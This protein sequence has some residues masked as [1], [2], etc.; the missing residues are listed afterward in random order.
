MGVCALQQDRHFRMR[1][2]R[3]PREQD[4]GGPGDVPAESTPTGRPESHR[5]CLGKAGMEHAAQ[6]QARAKPHGAN[7]IRMAADVH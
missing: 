6:R 2:K 7:T 5:W 3:G 1:G 4:R